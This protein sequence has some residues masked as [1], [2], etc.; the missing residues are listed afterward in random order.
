ML[1]NRQQANFGT[2]YLVTRA[3]SLEQQNAGRAHARLCH[4]ATP[5]TVVSGREGERVTSYSCRLL[6]C[7]VYWRLGSDWL[8]CD[9][10]GGGEGRWCATVDDDTLLP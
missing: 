3:Y 7:I 9:V 2:C 1:Y 4:A 6:E 5:E 8:C 10:D